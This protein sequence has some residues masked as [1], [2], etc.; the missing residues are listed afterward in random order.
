MSR[1]VYSSEFFD[2]IDV[3]SRA[4]ARKVANLLLQELPVTSLLDVGSGHGAWAAEWLRAG[5]GE[6]IA[7]DSGPGMQNV[8]ASMRDGHSTAGSP[9]LGLGSISRLTSNLDIYS[10]RGV[11]TVSRFEVWAS[12]APEPRAAVRSGAI[13]VAK[14]GET[15]S[16]DLWEA[17]PVGDEMTVVVVDGLG[18]GRGAHEAARAVLAASDPG[19]QPSAALE[20]MHQAAKPTRGA[21]GAVARLRPRARTVVFAGLGNISG[22]VSTGDAQHHMVSSN[23]T[24]GHQSQGLREYVYQWPAGS[25]LVLFSD[26][27]TSHWALDRYPGLLVRHPSL[28]AAVL[29]RDHS[30]RRDDVTVVVARAAA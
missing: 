28:V 11:G 10:Q 23:G 7:V 8:A 18:H 6:V 3:G 13:C 9:G 29:Y 21:A 22:L 26:G 30:R 12:D 4:S 15:V 2:Y 20:R 24:L 25:T 14:P 19:A 17:V 1:H 16:G 5:V 27:L